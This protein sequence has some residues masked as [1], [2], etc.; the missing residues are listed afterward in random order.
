M[1]GLH[2]CIQIHACTPMQEVSLKPRHRG[3]Q[4]TYIEPTLTEYEKHQA[5]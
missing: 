5:I 3:N 4:R 2:D 1:E